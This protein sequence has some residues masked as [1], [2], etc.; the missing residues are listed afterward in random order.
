MC[1]IDQ[2]IIFISYPIL[3]GPLPQT[4][5]TKYK[6][7]RIP[8]TDKLKINSNRVVTIQESSVLKLLTI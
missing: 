2:I 3:N 5:M 7:N 8:K 4:R 6:K 1:N